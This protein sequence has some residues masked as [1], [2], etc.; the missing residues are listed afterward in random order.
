MR[1][2]VVIKLA[3]QEFQLPVTFSEYEALDAVGLCPYRLATAAAQMGRP[4]GLSVPQACRA[5]AIGIAARQR[6]G[7]EVLTANDI[8]QAARLRD[9]GPVEVVD[10]GLDYLAA[11]IR[12]MGDPEA[13]PKPEAADGPKA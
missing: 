7:A 8:W 13:K 2:T 12:D 11:F 5:L 4:F 1:D 3:G 10:A 9:G 6:P